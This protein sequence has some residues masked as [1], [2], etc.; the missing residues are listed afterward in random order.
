M[1]LAR[2]GGENKNH[3]QKK[4]PAQTPAEM[5]PLSGDRRSLC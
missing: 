4:Q 5:K 2:Q 3:R 1:R